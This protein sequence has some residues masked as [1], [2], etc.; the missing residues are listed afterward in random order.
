MSRTF[1]FVRHIF[2]IFVYPTNAWKSAHPTINIVR[3]NPQL[4][5]KSYDNVAISIEIE[6]SEAL[7][8]D[9]S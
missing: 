7:W 8:D 1:L 4:H 5:A 6:N 3:K 2:R 9:T